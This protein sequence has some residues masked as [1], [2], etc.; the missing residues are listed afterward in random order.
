MIASLKEHLGQW[1]LK[2]E[3]DIIG[4]QRLLEIEPMILDIASFH[5]QQAIEKCF[6]AFLLYNGQEIVKTHDVIFLQKECAK[7]DPVFATIDVRDINLYAVGT[8]YPDDALMPEVEEAKYF[9]QLSQQVYDLVKVR[10][11]F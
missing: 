2:A 5:C 3:H 10:L 1:M 8:R 6:K 9:Y 11:V 7:L 4:A